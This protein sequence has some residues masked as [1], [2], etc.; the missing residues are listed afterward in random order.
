MDENLYAALEAILMVI[1]KPATS[2]DLASA[3]GVARTQVEAALAELQAEYA[4]ETPGQRKRGWC[5]RQLAGG[6]RIYSAPEYAPEVGEFLLGNTTARL[7]AAALETLA[8]VAY[9]QPVSRAVIAQVRGVNVDGVVRTLVAHNLIEPAGQSPS[10][11]VLYQTTA[12]FL[13][14]LGLDDLRQLPPL[15]PYLPQNE[16]LDQIAQQLKE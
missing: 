16:E 13:E 8:V 3:L 15:A 7:S 5:L 4:G 10:G 9:K 6:W 11:A 12:E 2:Q 14:R 1:D